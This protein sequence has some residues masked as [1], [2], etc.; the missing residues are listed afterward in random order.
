MAYKRIL[1]VLLTLAMLIT[2]IPSG[3]VSAEVDERTQRTVYLHAQGPNPTE[4]KNSSTVYMGETADLYFAID[5]PNKGAM[6]GDLHLEPHFDLNGYTVKIYFDPLYFAYVASD[7][8]RPIDYTV[9]DSKIKTSDKDNEEVGD[10]KVEDDVPQSVGYYEYRHGSDSKYINGKTYKTA[11]ATIFFS[12]TY[13]PNMTKGDLWYN[14]CKLPLTPLRTGST[15]VFIDIDGSDPYTL[16]LFAKNVTGNLEEQTFDFSAVNGGFHN[17]IIKDKNK[18]TAPVANPA[19]GVYTTAQKV[20]L[21]AEPGSTIYWSVDGGKTYVKFEEPI[22]VSMNTD[23]TCYAVRDSDGRESNVVTYSYDII[24]PAPFLFDESKSLLPNIHSEYSAFTVYVDDSSVFDNIADEHEIYYTFSD[25]A[26]SSV[27]DGS[28]PDNEWVKIEKALQTIDIDKKCT[29]RLVTKNVVTGELSEVAWYYLGIKPKVVTADPISGEYDSKIDVELSTETEGATIY[30]TTDGTDPITNGLEYSVPLTLAKDTTVRAVAMYD[31]EYSGISSFWYVFTAYDDYGVDAFYPSGV[32]EGSVNVTLTPNNPQNTIK[33]RYDD[34]PEGEWRDYDDVLVIDKD[35]TIIAKAIDPD[36]TEGGEYVFT[37]KIEPIPPEFAP[38]STQFTNADNVTIYCPESTISNTDRFELWYT[39]D[40]TDPV[41]SKTAKMADEESDSVTIKISDYTV[42]SAVV[43]KDGTTYSDVV[44]HSYDIVTKK[45]V[46]PITTLLPGNYTHEID[47]EEGFSTQFMPVPQGTEIY[48]TICY[49]GKFCPDPVPGAEG[50]ILY[51]GNPIEVKGHTVIKAVAKSVVFNTTSDIGIF[52]YTITPEAPVAAP[53]AVISGDTLPVVP[54][55]AVKGS[56]VNYDINGV[57]NEFV[58]DDGEFYIDT[59]TGNAYDDYDG[60]TLSNPLGNVNDTEINAPAVLE[61]TGTL[62]DI[63]SQPNRYIY[64]LSSEPTHLAPPYADKK[65][66]TYEEIDIDG[67]NNLLHVKLYSLNT[68]ADI[69]YMLNNDSVWRDYTDGEIIKLSE[70]TVLQARAVKDGAY[71]DASSYVY[72]FVP[73]APIITLASGRYDAD[74]L[75]STY[76]ELDERAPTDTSKFKYSIWYRVNGD[77]GDNYYR[78]GTERDIEHTMS[79]K[80]Y[81][82]NDV[83]GSVSAN[84]IHYYIIESGASAGGK[85]YIATPYDVERI[86]AHVL[87]EKPYSEGIK[88]FTREDDVEIHYFYTYK[89]TDGKSATTNNL[90]YDIAAPI[91]VNTLMDDISITA[92]L[93]DKDGARIDDSESTFDIDFIHLKNAITSLEARDEVEFEKGTKYTIIDDYPDDDTIDLYYTLDGSDPSD[94]DNENRKKYNGEQL[95]L[96][97]ATTVKTVYHSTCGKCVE[98]KDDNPEDCWNEVYGPVSTYKYTVPTVKYTGGGGGGGGGGSRTTTVDN[99]RKYTK[100]IF[101]NEH[102]TH[103][104]YIKGYPDGSVQPDGNIT[105]EE[106]T[107]ILYRITNHAYESPFVITGDVFPDVG[108]YRWSV[109]EIEYM[110]DKDVVEGY[111]DGEFKPAGALTRAEFA[112]LITRF[113]K[114]D[115]P[116]GDNPYPDVAEDHWA[117]DYI[118]S[119][120]ESGL[121]QGYEDG[122]FRAEKNITRAEVMTVVNKILG[123]CPYDEYVKTLEV[124]PFNDLKT[125]KWYYVIVLEATITHNYYLNDKETLEIKWE[126]IK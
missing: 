98:C 79:F 116:E 119:L 15:D 3:F 49:D 20:T 110:T 14:L 64:D 99:T 25:A 73:L 17:I 23:I 122:S 38:E 8:A 19:S 75:P 82:K 126:D 22:D 30:Y 53:G 4:T 87:T 57:E 35:T 125:E 124:N 54:V 80:A 107:V 66:G 114:L 68:G 31:G 51:D 59:A 109:L 69:Q 113:V 12:G 27:A 118:V 36:G 16:E 86:S 103:I 2:L 65:T 93:V 71:S 111:P 39:T 90:V 74:P 45:P 70:N 44:T 21:T 67:E 123:R 52:D 11:Y 33:Y 104:G 48:Y 121:M 94:E 43:K 47:N 61:I 117:H 76:I 108:K 78:L 5:N 18:P 56:T 62:D 83:T 41:T 9:P 34:D 29:V 115:E 26:V 46:K 106:M 77:K 81:V 37:Y 120:H 13:L 58:T 55:E 50:T 60:E 24:P 88:L 40:G 100:D 7:T 89:T 63:T 91:F 85:V 84:T 101:G 42:I 105:R 1:A 97:E 102:P 92:W 96:D 72:N 28:D 95:S 10:G 6:D 112:A 32:Y